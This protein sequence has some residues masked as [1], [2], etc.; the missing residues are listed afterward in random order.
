[1]FPEGTRSKDGKMQPFKEGAFMLAKITKTAILPVVIDGNYDIMPQ[2][3]IRLKRKQLFHVKVLPAVSE[4]EFS[5]KSVKELA[6]QLYEIMRAAHEAIAPGKYAPD[7]DSLN[8]GT[9]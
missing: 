5:Q 4:E 6:Q 2:K 8:S 1:M 7:T 3:G 9:I